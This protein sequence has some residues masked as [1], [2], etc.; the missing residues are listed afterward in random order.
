MRPVVLAALPY[1]V[2]L[3]VGLLIYRR[4]KQTLQGQGT[5]R[6]TSQEIGEFRHQIWRHINTLLTAS[7]TNADMNKDGVFWLFARQE[8]SDADAVLYGFIVGALVCSA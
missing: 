7:K 3:V 4:N 8:P 5:L 6:Y 1:P 2:Q